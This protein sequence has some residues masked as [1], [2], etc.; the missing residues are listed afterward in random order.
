[1]KMMT[2]AEVAAYVQCNVRTI[3][4]QVQNG[5]LPC[6]RIGTAIRFKRDEVEQALK[7]GKECQK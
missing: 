1:M 2:A 5:A 4:R 7:G 3:Y 6:Y